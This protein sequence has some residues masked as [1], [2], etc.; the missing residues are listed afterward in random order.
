MRALPAV[1]D[2]ARIQ[3]YGRDVG[4]SHVIGEREWRTLRLK[5]DVH[6]D[7]LWWSRPEYMPRVVAPACAAAT[8][9]TG[10]EITEVAELDGWLLTHPTELAEHG[11][12]LTDAF[13]KRAAITQ[14]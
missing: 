7:R 10:A 1:A 3:R 11:V 6:K 8:K 4:G 2:L 14:R 12:K 9:I 13:K 5:W